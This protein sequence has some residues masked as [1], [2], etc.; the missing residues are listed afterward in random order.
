MIRNR[1]QIT[2]YNTQFFGELLTYRF[3]VM[4]LVGDLIEVLEERAM[5]I[6]KSRSFKPRQNGGLMSVTLHG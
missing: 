2:L 1:Y 6:V 3:P 4:P 5:F